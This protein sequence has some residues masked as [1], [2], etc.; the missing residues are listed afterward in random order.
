M[1]GSK[2][3]GKGRTGASVV[4]IPITAPL[5][6]I[7]EQASDMPAH[8]HRMV[9]VL[10][11]TNSRQG[12][13]KSFLYAYG[14]REKLKPLAKSMTLGALNTDLDWIEKHMDE[15]AKAVPVG[16]EDRPKHSCKTLLTGLDFLIKTLHALELPVAT[17]VEEIKAIMSKD[18]ARVADELIKTKKYTEIDSV[19]HD[20]AMMAGMSEGTAHTAGNWL[21][22][23]RHYVRKGNKLI[24]DAPIIHTLYKR[25]KAGLHET[26]VIESTQQFLQLLKHESYFEADNYLAPQ[27][28]KG[29]GMTLLNVDKLR[30]KGIIVDMFLES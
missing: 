19:M 12:C 18:L 20:M 3:N 15:N 22:A 27:I 29:R 13:E 11:N 9:Q 17:K 14:N 24:I 28:V 26:V 5:L 23:G 7:S 1:S 30:D 10:M 4:S 16:L 25:Y 2:A 6:V 8:R 21:I